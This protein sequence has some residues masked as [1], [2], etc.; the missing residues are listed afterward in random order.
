MSA[1]RDFYENECT[2]SRAKKEEIELRTKMVGELLKARK[3][4]G[5][6]KY[7]ISLIEKIKI[8]PGKPKKHHKKRAS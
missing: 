7:D 4:K 5:L 1:W 6:T 2:L 3:G 8:I